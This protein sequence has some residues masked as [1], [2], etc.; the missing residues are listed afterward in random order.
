MAEALRKVLQRN[1]TAAL[2]RGELGEAERL[3]QVLQEEDPLSVETRGLELEYLICCKRLGEAE[4]LAQQ[5][6]RLFPDSARVHYLAGRLAYSLR[7]YQEAAGRFRESD[8]LYPH[9]F[10]QLFLGKTLTQQGQFD[11]AESILTRLSPAHAAA[12]RDLSW[13]YERMGDRHRALQEME[14]LLAVFPDDQFALTQLRRLRALCLQPEVIV[15]EF[16][17][18]RQLGEAVE[19]DMLPQY[20]ESLLRTGKGD[21]ARAVVQEQVLRA[22]PHIAVRAAWNC[23]RLQAFDMSYALFVACLPTQLRNYKML[24]ALEASARRT[25]RLDELQ[26]LYAQYAS[27]EPSLYGRLRNLRSG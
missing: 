1:L 16:D 14:S 3:L 9:W 24:A 6:I 8:R 25:G 21:R 12:R 11:E 4:P 13:L 18:L 23:Y 10:T 20:V 27:I 19:P 15:E 26:T 22:A 2:R 17:Q 7:N 5:L